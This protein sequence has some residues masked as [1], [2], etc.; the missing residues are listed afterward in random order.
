MP[1]A[2]AAL[3]PREP[4]APLS[5]EE[6]TAAAAGGLAALRETGL[7]APAVPQRNVLSQAIVGAVRAP[8]TAI[9]QPLRALSAIPGLRGVFEPAAE[10]VA[11]IPPDP[12]GGFVES[13]VESGLSFLMS[14]AGLKGLPLLAKVFTTVPRVTTGLLSIFGGAEFADT[15]KQLEDINKTLPAHQQIPTDEITRTAIIAA[16]A[17]ALLEGIPIPVALRR[18]LPG[19]ESGRG[20]T[21]QGVQAVGRAFGAPGGMLRE[22]ARRAAETCLA[23]SASQ[24]RELGARANDHADSAS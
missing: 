18:I 6:I 2:L 19:V 10:A 9:E 22:T 11:A 12:S 4:R 8:F 15:R 5:D 7:F 1:P 21:E 17:E 16:G 23:K 13:G 24:W 3:A 14:V 20:I